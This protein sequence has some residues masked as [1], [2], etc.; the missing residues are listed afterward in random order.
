M[1]ALAAVQHGVNGP[2]SIAP[3]ISRNIQSREAFCHCVGMSKHRMQR[4]VWK[5]VLF[6]KGPYV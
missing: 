2:L 4:M 5:S 6:S 1:F 3:S